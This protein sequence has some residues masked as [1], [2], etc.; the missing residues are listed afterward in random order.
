MR[1][2][3]GSRQRDCESHA[4]PVERSEKSEESKERTQRYERQP[5]GLPLVRVF[6]R[7]A[8]VIWL[9]A[10]RS[11]VTALATP[12][13]PGSRCAVTY[14]TP[15]SSHVVT[16][17]VTLFWRVFDEPS[18]LNLQAYLDRGSVGLHDAAATRIGSA[19]DLVMQI[20]TDHAR[21]ERV[22]AATLRAGEAEPAIRASFRKLES[23]YAGARFADVYFVIGRFIVGGVALPHGIVVGAE[24]YSDPKQLP[25]IVAHELVHCQQTASPDGQTL[26][27]RAFNEGSADF[28]GE[29]ISGAQIN[30]AAHAYGLAHE[31]A[32]WSE[33]KQH[34]HDTAYYPWMYGPRADGLPNDLGYFIG[35]RIAQ[36]Y[37]DRARDKRAAVREIIRTN[38]VDRLLRASGY[39][40]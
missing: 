40:P 31:H 12:P 10:C 24:M 9:A 21:Y 26:L 14:A 2:E 15:D 13:A 7:V 38:Y 29:L 8:V 25:A 28:V 20:Q 6:A 37:Y 16:S 34:R 30:S 11:R 19:R 1:I 39:D 17:D 27:A 22:R 35:Y 5:I 36:A 18:E 32:L 3:G 33:F 23:L 4:R